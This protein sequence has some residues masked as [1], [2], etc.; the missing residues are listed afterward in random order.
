M[1]ALLSND[2]C[3]I[4][5]LHGIQLSIFLHDDT[6]DFPEPTLSNHVIKLKMATADLN[7]LFRLPFLFNYNLALF[8]IFVRKLRQVNLETILGFLKRFLTESRIATRVIFLILF[9]LSRG[10]DNCAL[11]A[12]GLLDAQFPK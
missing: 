9:L 6:P 4:H 2:L 1:N 3:L 11:F 5:F 8:L 12:T 7:S 10:H